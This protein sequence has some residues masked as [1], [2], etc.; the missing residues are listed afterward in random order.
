MGHKIGNKRGFCGLVAHFAEAPLTHSTK[1]GVDPRLLEASLA[2]PPTNFEIYL[3]DTTYD[4]G[5]NQ[6]DS[7][8]EKCRSEEGV[9][10]GL[11][12]AMNQGHARKVNGR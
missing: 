5:I 2:K 9:C 10:G 8:M 6:A 11:V 4:Q 12:V 7:S 3:A 1:A